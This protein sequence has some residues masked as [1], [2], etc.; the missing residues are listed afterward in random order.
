MHPDGPVG[1][2]LEKFL[3]QKPTNFSLHRANTSFSNLSIRIQNE[4]NAVH[5]AFIDENLNSQFRR[6]P[7]K[8]DRKLKFSG[9]FLL[10]KKEYSLVE[11]F[12]KDETEALR[13]ITGI[14]L[15]D[16]KIKHSKP[17]SL[18]RR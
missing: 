6:F 2:L 1:F 5:P 13:S 17:I 16:E 18:G 14:D 7:A 12:I 8:V 4:F 3:N 9:K 10:T 11:D 15:S